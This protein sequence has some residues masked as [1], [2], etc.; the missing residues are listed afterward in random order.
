MKLQKLST[1][2]EMRNEAGKVIYRKGLRPKGIEALILDYL[3]NKG[4]LTASE[5]AG[6]LYWYESVKFTIKPLLEQM[7]NMGLLGKYGHQYCMANSLNVAGQ[8]YRVTA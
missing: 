8:H 6:G 4:L 7:V 3:S 5:V 1:E 2:T